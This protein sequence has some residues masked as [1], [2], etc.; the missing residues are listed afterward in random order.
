[1]RIFLITFVT[2]TVVGTALWQFGLAHTTWPAHP[3]LTTIVIAA[4]CGIAVQLVISN[5]SARDNSR[6]PH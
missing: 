2:S 5:D 3:P 6:L 4:A 1:V